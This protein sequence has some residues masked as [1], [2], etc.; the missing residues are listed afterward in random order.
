MKKIVLS[1]A[2]YALQCMLSGLVGAVVMLLI[3]AV[4]FLNDK[5][6]LE[7][8]HT[9]ELDEE[10]TVDS[11]IT[12]FA[13]YLQLEARLFVQLDELIYLSDNGDSP[14]S[15]NRYTQHS[16]ADATSWEIN[17]NRTFELK[18]ESP[19]SGVLLL[20]GLSDA[21]YSLRT[22]A[23]RLH[24]EGAYVI[25]LRIPG[26]GTIPAALTKTTW[27]DMAAAVRIAMVHLKAVVGDQP[28]HGVGYSNGGALAVRYVLESLEDNSLPAL[29]SLSL[30]S[31]EIGIT[32]I[33]AFAIWQERIGYMLGMDKLQWQSVLPECDPYKYNSFPA[34]AGMLAHHLTVANRVQLRKL[35]EYDKLDRFPPILAFQSIVDATVSAPALVRDLFHR[36]PDAQH[37]LVVYDINRSAQI[38]PLLLE[39]K[40]PNVAQLETSVARR[41]KLTLVTNRSQQSEAVEVHIY[42]PMIDNPEKK[43][44]GHRWPPSIYS[45]SH[46]A[47]PFSKDD[48]LYGAGPRQDQTRIHLGAIAVRGE[49]GVFAISG[50]EMLRQRWNPFYDYQEDRIVEHMSGM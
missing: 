9:S 40:V 10:F 22:L 35:S 19:K 8:W 49:K 42:P 4:K 50:D 23:E 3:V 44:L 14:K 36:L 48:P 17:W 37:E 32:P 12:N 5:P 15:I 41:Y 28:L 27:Q 38:E 26:H 21:P 6:E 13:E 39:G 45:L 25:G 7:R 43:S 29:Q 34:N 31:P 18:H 16:L 2:S 11:P 1:T 24:A 46:V 47:L 30:L 33:A 20:H